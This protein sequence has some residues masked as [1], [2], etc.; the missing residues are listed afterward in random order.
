MTATSWLGTVA[1][2]F[3]KWSL[4]GSATST[5]SARGS[6]VAMGSSRSGWVNSA[7]TET[8]QTTM[9]AHKP[10]RF[11]SINAAM[12]SWRGEIWSSAMT[13]MQLMTTAVA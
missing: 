4:A 6:T 10:V 5:N 1:V 2:P 11:N 12:G 8:E 7:M 13:E 9:A 3:A